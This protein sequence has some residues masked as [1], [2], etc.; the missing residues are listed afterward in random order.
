MLRSSAAEIDLVS[1]SFEVQ[2]MRM[3]IERCGEVIELVHSF[4]VLYKRLRCLGLGVSA[5]SRTSMSLPWAANL[6]FLAPDV[7]A[8]LVPSPLYRRDE[9]DLRHG[10]LIGLAPCPRNGNSR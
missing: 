1:P 4:E 10:D 7:S 9:S 5:A 8:P 3:L 2:G 6:N